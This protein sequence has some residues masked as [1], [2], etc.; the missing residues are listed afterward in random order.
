MEL[1]KEVKNINEKITKDLAKIQ[2]Q[3]ED[4]NAKI[5]KCVD[6]HNAKIQ[7][8]IDD[9]ST[10]MTENN[11]KLQKQ[12][13]DVSEKISKMCEIQTEMMIKVT[14]IMTE[15]KQL[16][17][18]IPSQQLV[19][20][21]I[22]I[23]GGM[24]SKDINSVEIFSWSHKTWTLIKPMSTC[25]SYASAVTYKDE[26]IISGGNDGRKST[27]T[28]ETS[29]CDQSVEWKISPVKIPEVRGRHAT[30]IYNDSLLLSGGGIG[31][32][33]AISNKIYEISM[34]P[35]Y[36]SKILTTMPKARYDHTMELFEDKLFIFGGCYDG[37]SACDTVMMFNLVTKQWKM[38]TPLPFEVD[39]MAT[40]LW[41]DN[42]IVLGGRPTKDTVVMYNLTTGQS[43]YLPS[44]KHKRQG[45]TAVVTGDVLVVMGGKSENIGGYLKSVEVFHFKD[46]VWEELPDMNESRYHACAVVKP[47]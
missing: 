2:K 15:G 19:R 26:V 7:E 1:K 38:M 10:K 14:Q 33:S 8:Q 27:D 35:P 17:Q 42:F 4:H 44:M 47:S 37:V 31:A 41:Q 39:K 13:D 30:V 12:V 34:V 22:V 46:Q 25:R 6:D 5:Q 24:N 3:V 43:K 9:F 21:N 11:I 28:I 32:R 18:I 20:K 29:S 40:V 36:S 16:K 45:C 23:A